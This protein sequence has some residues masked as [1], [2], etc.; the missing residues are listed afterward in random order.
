M[1]RGNH[2]TYS[3]E[4]LRQ[5]LLSIG[6]MGI[7]VE[8][9]LKVGTQVQQLVRKANGM[10]AFILR[11]FG[12]WNAVRPAELFQQFLFLL[13][14]ERVQQTLRGNL[15]EELKVMRDLDRIDRKKLFP[16]QEE[17]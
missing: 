5:D 17:R 9:L 4:S 8:Q 14:I 10:L 2:N 13:A 16:L 15:I 7:M 6:V 3:H 1:L 11:G 12:Y